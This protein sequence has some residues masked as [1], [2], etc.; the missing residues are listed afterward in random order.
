MTSALPSQL[1]SKLNW[2]V[3]HEPESLSTGIGDV[4]ALIEGCP[5]GR[6]TE[7]AGPV[8]SGRTTLLHSILAEASRLGEFCALVDTSNSFDPHSAAAAGVNLK[9][10]VWIRC[11]GNADHAM[12]AADLLIHGGGFGVVAMDLCEVTPQMLR[13]IP[14]SYWY[15]FRR[16]I[17]TTPCAFVLLSREP[18]AKACASVLIEM[19]RDR[20]DFTGTSPLL[21]N[22]EFMVIPRKPIHPRTARFKAVS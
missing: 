18:Q 11:R 5:R 20:A 6:I 13:R 14:L 4:D 3:Q 2:K 22:A 16:A 7:I 8:S 12:R 10:L 19:K 9:R 15:R 1:L 21:K 17:E